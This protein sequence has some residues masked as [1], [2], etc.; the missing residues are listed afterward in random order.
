MDGG[1]WKLLG[2]CAGKIF[3]RRMRWRGTEKCRGKG[4]VDS[5]VE[6]EKMPRHFLRNIFKDIF[7]G[8]YCR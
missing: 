1:D 8:G 4:S 3:F 2:E 5:L 7:D 6:I